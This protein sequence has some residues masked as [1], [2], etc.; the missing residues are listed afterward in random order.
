MFIV[1]RKSD[2]TNTAKILKT[3]AVRGKQR[4]QTI[5]L[6][7]VAFILVMLAGRE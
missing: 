4:T 7:T 1:H 6:K 5:L 2:Q 3:I